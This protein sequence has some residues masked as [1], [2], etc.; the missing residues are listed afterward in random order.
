MGGLGMENSMLRLKS[1]TTKPTDMPFQLIRVVKCV[2][3]RGK[4]DTHTVCVL[5]Y[6]V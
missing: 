1:Y 5:V 4:N 6:H 2:Q 3:R